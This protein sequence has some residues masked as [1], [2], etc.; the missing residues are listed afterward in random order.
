MSR[1]IEG[2][3]A[4]SQLV[5][6]YAMYNYESALISIWSPGDYEK[7]QRTEP[8]LIEDYEKMRK[9]FKTNIRQ[10][11]WD[12]EDNVPGY[13]TISKEQAQE[14][15]NF[16][17]INHDKKFIIH[18]DAGQSRSAGVALAVECILEYNGDK[19]EFSKNTSYVSL[20]QYSPNRKVYDKIM[21]AYENAKSTR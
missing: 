4:R 1:V 13:D 6:T 8:T 2:V 11:F 16:I 14:I 9:F 21:E 10:E 15:V 20:P 19:Y 17:L 3:M 5:N 7:F 12:T 18:C